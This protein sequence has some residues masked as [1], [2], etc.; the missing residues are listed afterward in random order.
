MFNYATVQ[1]NFALLLAF[2]M[3]ILQCTNK[4]AWQS[5]P[6]QNVICDF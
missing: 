2:W 1:R 5:K 6:E 4:T 3:Q